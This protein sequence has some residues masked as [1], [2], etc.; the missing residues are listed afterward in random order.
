MGIKDLEF[1]RIEY[2]GILAGSFAVISGIFQ[3][4]KI[5]NNRSAEDISMWALIGALISTSIWIYYHYTKKGGGPFLTTTTTFLFLLVA[6]FLKVYYDGLN[7]N[8]D[9]KDDV[10]PDTRL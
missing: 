3:V 9:K 10:A 6:L 8:K 1:N 2:L 7:K 4:V 5:Y